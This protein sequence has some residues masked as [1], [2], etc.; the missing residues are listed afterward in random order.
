MMI[1]AALCGATT[2][3]GT[4]LAIWAV[5]QNVRLDWPEIALMASVWCIVSGGVL[6][7]KLLNDMKGEEE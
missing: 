5:Y 7:G 3:A 2:T 6:M 1:R 4:I